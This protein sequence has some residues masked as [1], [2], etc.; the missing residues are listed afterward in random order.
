MLNEFSLDNGLNIKTLKNNEKEIMKMTIFFYF[1]I[2]FKHFD[3]FYYS[4]HQRR[5]IKRFEIKS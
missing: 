3:G 2:I 4:L 5:K 1:S